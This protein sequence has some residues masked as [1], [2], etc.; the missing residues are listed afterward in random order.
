MPVYE[1]AF[2]QSNKSSTADLAS[3]YA[4]PLIVGSDGPSSE[5]SIGHQIA[6]V[7]ATTSADLSASPATIAFIL[8]EIGNTSYE[9]LAV[10]TAT[11]TSTAYSAVSDGSGGDYLATVAFTESA[12]SK[13]DLL[14]F[15]QKEIAISGTTVSAQRDTR[16][17]WYLS[18]ITLSSGTMKV[19][20]A[21]TR[22][23]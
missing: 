11:V 20:V 1:Y 17:V 5:T 8:A 19:F 16:L 7:F 10:F 15:G 22:A 14:G 13:I 23:L 18:C 4:L 3:A 9:K 2:T 6:R 21:P 12:D